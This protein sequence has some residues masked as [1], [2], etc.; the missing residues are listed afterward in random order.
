METVS[1]RAHFSTFE[2]F[3]PF[4]VSQHRLQ[5]TRAWHFVGTTLGLFC[6]AALLA[7]GSTW[8]FPVGLASSYGCA[9]IGHVFFE[10]NRPATFTHPF[11]SLLGDLKMYAL[12]W[13][14]KMTGEAARVG[15]TRNRA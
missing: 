15:E 4:Y 2:E 8:L 5:S 14:G 6:L 12:M 7:T 11:Y 9:W 1:V 10:K 13:R 3:W